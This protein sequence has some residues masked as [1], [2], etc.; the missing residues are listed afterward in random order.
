M[1]LYKMNFIAPFLIQS[2][3]VI[4]YMGITIIG[5]MGDNIVKGSLERDE[6]NKQF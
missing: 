3:L 2:L 5:L 4:L 1:F 6:K